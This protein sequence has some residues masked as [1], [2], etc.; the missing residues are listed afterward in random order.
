MLS[1]VFIFQNRLDRLIT[2]N[3]IYDYKV[4]YNDKLIKGEIVNNCQYI[5]SKSFQWS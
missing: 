5:R 2:V 3:L 1:L 4:T